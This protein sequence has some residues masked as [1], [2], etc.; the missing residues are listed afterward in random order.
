MRKA[1][2]CRPCRPCHYVQRVRFRGSRLVDFR[3]QLCDNR[4]GTEHALITKVLDAEGRM[5]AG[6]QE[7]CSAASYSPLPAVEDE[8]GVVIG[9]DTTWLLSSQPACFIIIPPDQWHFAFCICHLLSALP[10]WLCSCSDIRRLLLPLRALALRHSLHS[11]GRHGSKGQPNRNNLRTPL[12]RFTPSA[13]LHLKCPAWPYWKD[14]TQRPR[15]AYSRRKPANRDPPSDIS[16]F[17]SC[18]IRHSPA[19]ESHVLS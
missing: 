7:G 13:L 2:P 6:W 8:L 1:S 16:S 11:L 15:L 14:A 5:P 9:R 19:Q 10:S 18:S 4:A 12:P 3:S 17:L